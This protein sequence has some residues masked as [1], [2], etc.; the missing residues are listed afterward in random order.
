MTARLLAGTLDGS[1][2]PFR[3]VQPIMMLDVTLPAGARFEHDVPA[4]LDNAMAFVHKVGCRCCGVAPA[5]ALPPAAAR[6]GSHGH[7]R[8]VPRP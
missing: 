1:E 2:G 4:G 3:T 7:P 5:A 8:R 6:V